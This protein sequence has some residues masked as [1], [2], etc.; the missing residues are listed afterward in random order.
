MSVEDPG[1]PVPRK[2]SIQQQQQQLQDQPLATIDSPIS[3]TTVEDDDDD[4]E[5]GD[6]DNDNPLTQ[7]SFSTLNPASHSTSSLPENCTLASSKDNAYFH[8]LFKSV[9]EHDRLLESKY[10]TKKTLMVLDN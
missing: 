2:M 7:S 5:G 9:P 3:T 8:A 4:D 1:T 6:M 10:G